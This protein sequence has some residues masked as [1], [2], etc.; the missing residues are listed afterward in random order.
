MKID[1]HQRF[2]L[3]HIAKPLIK[4]GV[5][6]P[7]A[8]DLRRLAAFPNV[9]CKASG[10]VTEA[11]WHAWQPSDFAPYLDVV[12]EAFGVERVMIGSDWPVCTVSAPYGRVMSIVTDYVRRFSPAEQARVL[13]QNA[14]E[15]YGL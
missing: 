3:D 6:E 8:T 14:Q 15:F 1:A 10:L 5:R 12:F 4:A 11:D 9:W 7:W 2:V 13:G